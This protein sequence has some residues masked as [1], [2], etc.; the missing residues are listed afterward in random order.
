MFKTLLKLKK[1]LVMAIALMA[2]AGVYAQTQ[3]TDEAGLKA[4]ADDL[5]GSYVLANDITLS[6]EW[7]PIGTSGTPFTGMFDGGGHTIKG[8]TIKSGADN[9]GFFAFTKGATI[10]N[11]RFT[12]ANILGNKQ[13][14]IVAGQASA[15]EITKVFTSGTLVGYDHIGGIV[16]DARIG[17]DAGDLTTI[18]D[19]MSTAGAFSTTHQGGGIAGWTNGAVF[20]NVIFLGSATAPSNGAGGIVSIIDG[21]TANVKGSVGAPVM[22]SGANN[23]VHS[24]IGWSNGGSYIAEN[25]LSSA[26]TV[27]YSAGQKVDI[28]TLEGDFQGTLT[29]VED[30]KKA[31]TYTGIGFN[32]STW[33]LADGV[34]PVLTGMTYPLDGD[35]IAVNSLPAKCVIGKTY[36]SR[37]M[38]ALQRPVTL[39]S[40][41]TDAV[42]V[43]GT[44]L[45]FV[46]LGDAVVT[47]TTA[48]DAFSN[49]ATF[50]QN[51]HVESMNYNLSTVEDLKEM[52][53]N[54]GGDYKLMNDIDLAGENWTPLGTFTGTFDGQGH[55][56]KN[57][58]IKKSTSRV[59]F[60]EVAQNATIQNLGFENANVVGGDQ[61]VG[62]IVGQLQGSTIK[63]CYVANS[64]IEGHDHTGALVGMIRNVEGLSE[65]DPNMVG[66]TVSN[67]I[68]DSHVVSLYYQA[69]GL[70]GVSRGGLIEHCI[71]T[72][73]VECKGSGN[74]TGIV[75]L[76]DVAGHDAEGKETI[77][78]TTIRNN[79]VAASHIY[80]SM[81]RRVTNPANRAV[82][83]ENNYAMETVYIGSDSNDAGV[84]ENQT[85]ATSANAAN[86]AD[87]TAKTKAFLTGLGFD[88]D[89]NWKYFDGTEGKMLPVLK[90]MNAPLTTTI[91]DMPLNKSILYKDGS[92][93]ISLKCVHASW[94]Q[95]INFTLT[96]GSELAS[97]SEEEVALYAGDENGNFKGSGD[98]TV[99]V[100]FADGL[101]SYFTVSGDDS[102]GVYIGE[103]STIT[104][105][106]TV[107][108]FQKIT[109]NLAG[110][111]RLTTDIDMNGVEFHPLG[112]KSAQFSGT[113]DGDG[114]KILNMTINETGGSEI[115]FF[116]YTNNATIKNLAFVNA[117]INAPSSNHVGILA[118]TLLS[119]TVDQ[120][121][122]A[123]TV[124]GNDHVAGL[125]GD[126]N[127]VA[128]TNTYVDVNVTGYSQVGGF[129]GCTTGSLN[130][131]NSYYNG[132]ASV[133][134]RGWVGGIIG[135]IDKGNC[136]I[137]INNC[138]SIGNLASVG[139][140]SPHAAS[141]F[142]GGNGP[143]NSPN[144]IVN[145]TNN[146]INDN[147]TINV[148]GDNALAWPT[149]NITVEG[150][151][152]EDA[153]RVN[154]ALLK[155]ASTYTD[156]GWNFTDIWS[157][158]P[159]DAKYPYP[160][161]K[162]FGNISTGI[163]DIITNDTMV[164]YVISASDNVL[165]VAGID[166]TAKV[167]VMNVAGQQV[168]SVNVSSGKAI[169]ALPGHGLYII[170]IVN[171]GTMKSYKVVNN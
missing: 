95:D 59:G 67:C 13:A 127:S 105:I 26:S 143:G 72:G 141:A 116:S 65:D 85:D 97:Y 56:I 104:E 159:A 27:I 33:I 73:I 162:K 122:V 66:G 68:S 15:T 55:V 125:A 92:E 106:S 9:V 102:F 37:A 18:S 99:K 88:F 131:S 152:V 157:I 64:Y 82:T 14:G 100:L 31:S 24:I 61:D 1:S 5:A 84:M 167:Y 63:N 94:G 110:N 140:G 89:N 158:D 165:T 156:L 83:L 4:I 119:G 20:T 169:F 29:S 42:V 118:G 164:G 71:F 51:I 46:G 117:T 113:L 142:I 53:N 120:V 151:N 32:T 149:K 163:N 50:T 76:I 129:F 57:M 115:G 36:S 38:S 22:L 109:R 17:D 112:S 44:N 161:L 49:G 90:W 160:V 39:T 171:N 150:G 91:F 60:F 147:A 124:I 128:V 8:L 123:G 16:G 2:S 25:N 41:N 93:A 155:V 58:T 168:G 80:G 28:S 69:G 40:S 19:C 7:V 103:S 98:V 11:V 144:A 81:I 96:Q 6:E 139:K 78:T 108:D 130:V 107:D 47:Y 87:K 62:T 10:Q 154:A 126:G 74:V 23:K 133:T 54:L 170:T 3:I 153:T 30:L 135:L 79:L 136:T 114:H 134:T 52:A 137:E 35:G 86:V 77:A 48:G 45:K 146:V 34:Y 138:V 132:S 166:G 121:A 12:G 75:S 148:E 70:V 101:A 145:F 21:G 111:Y 43:D